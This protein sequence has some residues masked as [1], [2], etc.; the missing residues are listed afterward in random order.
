[1]CPVLAHIGSATTQSP[2]GDAHYKGSRVSSNPQ[3]S[4]ERGSCSGAVTDGAA[5]AE[6]GW[7]TRPSWAPA[8]LGSGRGGVQ[9]HIG[10]PLAEDPRGLCC[11]TLA[12]VYSKSWPVVG[13]VVQQMA[14]F[15]VCPGSR[16]LGA[17]W[18]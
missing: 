5:E 1:M 11:S 17:S 12:F 8:Q 4:S 13:V 3:G 18:L 2:R 10:V 7:G 15:P 16:H 6:R 14:S 9:I